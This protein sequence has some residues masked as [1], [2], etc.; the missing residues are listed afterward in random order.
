MMKFVFAFATLTL[1]VASAASA[2]RYKVQ[3]SEPSQINGQAVKP[4][5]YTLELKDNHAVLKQGKTTIDTEARIES[6]DKKFAET[7][8]RY[9]NGEGNS[10][11]D[12]IRLSGTTTKVVFTKAQASGN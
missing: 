4:G 3:I 2:N 10:K 8:V 1:A 6:A 11:I 9:S 7:S 5:E 12:E